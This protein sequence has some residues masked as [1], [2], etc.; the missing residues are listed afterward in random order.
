MNTPQFK[1]Y[2]NEIASFADDANDVLYDHSGHITFERLRKV[3]TIT[4]QEDSATGAVSVIAGD[5][6]LSFKQYL[7]EIADLRQF[8]SKLIAKHK[9]DEFFYVDPDALHVSI[10]GRKE[11]SAKTALIAECRT[12]N[13][14]TKICFITADAGHGKTILLREFEGEQ[15]KLFLEGKVDKLFWHVDLHGRTLVR[16]NEVLMSELGDLRINGLY[17]N[18]IITLIKRG[19]IVLGID[20]FD[21]LSAEIGGDKALGSLSK[22]V[23]DLEG[24]GTIVAASRRAF[25]NTQDYV[26][27]SRIRGAIADGAECDF[28]EIRIKNWSRKQCIEYLSYYYLVSDATEQFNSIVSIL[29]NGEKHPVIARPFIFTKIVDD[30]VKEKKNPVDIIQVGSYNADGIQNV[31]SAFVRREVI[32]WGEIDR[33]TGLPYLTFDQHMQFLSEIA[34]EMW[35]EKRDWLSVETIQ[36]ILA[37]LIDGWDIEEAKKPQIFEMSRFHALLVVSDKGDEFRCFDHVE[38]KNYFLA[39]SLYNELNDFCDNAYQRFESLLQASQL[40]DSVAYYF[41]TFI[42]QDKKLLLIERIIRQEKKDWKLT[43]LKQNLGT[44]L[45]FLL[46]ELHNERI[47]EI[48]KDLAFSSLVFENKRI[49]NVKFINCLF[50]RISL[51]HT[52]LNNVFFSNCSF[53]DFRLYKNAENSFTNVT[54]DSS[55]VVSQVT[56]VNVDLEDEYSEY[57]PNNIKSLVNKTGINYISETIHDEIVKRNEV[58]RKQVKRFLNKFIKYSVQYEKNFTEPDYLNG[59]SP[60]LILDEIIPLLKKYKIIEEVDNRYT[61][62]L[63]SRAWIL[64]GYNIEDVFCGEEDTKSPLYQ[65]WQEVYAH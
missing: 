36:F 52:V 3:E 65:F 12:P 25:F 41:S 34:K 63:S 32:K 49:E 19:L 13:F 7:L 4:L 50:S 55:C 2:L 10:T 44:I 8:A 39:F 33:T 48:N 45:P 16:L 43:Y 59:I 37:V 42:P 56:I 6:K 9:K 61:A 62:F 46:S 1:L 28:D 35:S 60:N 11:C 40:P 5:K 21:E 17:Y 27:N 31:L 51:N 54:I 53:T 57:S 64:K 26:N 30:A 24:T 14:G 47:I 20:G 58:F 22:L 18:S 15:A 38:F 29:S 23:Q